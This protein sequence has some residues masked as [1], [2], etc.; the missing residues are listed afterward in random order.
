MAPKSSDH[1][2]SWIVSLSN[3]A[4]NLTEIVRQPGHYNNHNNLIEP[5]LDEFNNTC[6]D[7]YLVDDDQDDDNDTRFEDK[8][9][10]H[11][12]F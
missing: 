3:R 2:Q 9:A 7:I 5:V 10:D 8:F 6:N 12:W 4:I 1:V 11:L